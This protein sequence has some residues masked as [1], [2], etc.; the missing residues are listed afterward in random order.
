MKQYKP[1]RLSVPNPLQPAQYNR[2]SVL[3]R[4]ISRGTGSSAVRCLDEQVDQS[5]EERVAKIKARARSRIG[6]IVTQ[7]SAQIARIQAE[8][9]RSK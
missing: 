2:E 8:R 3:D 5:I 9:A 4:T 1:P 7:A 6:K